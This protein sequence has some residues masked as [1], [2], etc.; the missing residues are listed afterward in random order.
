VKYLALILLVSVAAMASPSLRGVSEG[1]GSFFP[2]TDDTFDSYVYDTSVCSSIPASFGDYRVVDD[3][4]YAAGDVTISSFIYWGLTTAAVP[5]TLN[6]M[7]F[8]NNA[9]MPGTELF[10]TSNAVTTAASGFTYAGYTVYVTTMPVSVDVP[11]NTTRWFGFHRPDSNTWYVGIGPVVTGFEAHR[12][13]AAGYSWAPMSSS[14]AAADLYKVV[15]GTVSLER[16]TWAGV[17][18]LF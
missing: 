16:T 6:L 1:S 2:E 12:T 14:I 11:I 10:Q 8:E 4:V 3:F 15:T 13:E 9:G 18:S 17:K 5:T 7:C